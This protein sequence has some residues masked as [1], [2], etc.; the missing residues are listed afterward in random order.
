MSRKNKSDG[1]L[2]LIILI[3]VGLYF[4]WPYLQD[5]GFKPSNDSKPNNTIIDTTD[6]IKLD[7]TRLIVVSES[8]N[9]PISEVNLLDDN[10]F[11]WEYLP[12]NGMDFL[13]LDPDD[14]THRSDIVAFNDQAKKRNI[15]GSYVAHVKSTKLFNMIPMPENTDALKELIKRVK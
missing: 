12:N 5:T 6:S 2:S 8:K 3:G 11:W 7:G 13:I 4:A 9:R 15:T 1:N 10:E 14:P